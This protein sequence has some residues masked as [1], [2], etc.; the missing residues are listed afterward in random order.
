MGARN[1]RRTH[2]G[3]P[4]ALRADIGSIAI[5]VVVIALAT[6]GGSGKAPESDAAPPPPGRF[7]HGAAGTARN[8][9]GGEIAP[10]PTM[11]SWPGTGPGANGGAFAFIGAHYG[12]RWGIPARPNNS[13]GVGYCVME[14]VAGERTV[15]L[16]PD[17][18]AWDRG[19]M[20]RAAAVM[21]SFGGDRVVPYTIDAAG[22]YDVAS[23]EW[24]HPR[25]L[26]GGE[27]T[28]RRHVAVNF[29][30]KMFVED[31]SP[32]GV[33]A[34]RKLARDTAVVAGAGSDFVAL[35]NGYEVA[36]HL[37]DVAD[38]HHAVGGITLQ[39][40]WETPDGAAPT[41]P[42]IHPLRVRVTDSTGKPVAFVP[43]LQL[44]ATGIGDARSSGASAAVAMSNKSADDRARWHAAAAT[45]WP[46]LTMSRRLGDDR[47]F[48]LG[49]NPRSADVTGSDGVARFDVTIDGPSWELAFHA[50]AP[51][52]DVE[53]YAGSGVQGQITWAGQP[54]SASSH[55]RMEMPGRIAVRKVLDAADIQGDRDMSGFVFDVLST[56]GDGAVVASASTGTEGVTPPIELPV[57]EYRV[58]ET[59]RPAWAAGLGDGGPVTIAVDPAP[60]ADAHPVEVVYV[61]A[62]PS[63]SITTHASDAADGDK[64]LSPAPADDPRPFV[65]DSVTYTGLVPGTRYIARGE[66]V[67]DDCDGWCTA[68]VATGETD[69]VAAAADG[70]VDVTFELSA[71]STPRGGG[72]GVVL[73]DLLV[74]ASGRVVAEHRDPD[75][76]A[77]TVYFPHLASRLQRDDGGPPPASWDE[78]RVDVGDAI[79]DVVDHTGL[80]PGLPHRIEMTLHERGDDGTCTP[81]GL[82]TT[83]DLTPATPTGRIEVRGLALPAPGVYVAFQ[84]LHLVD[85]VTGATRLVAAHADCGDDA[86][87]LWAPLP[88]PPSTVPEVPAATTTSSPPSTAAP[89]VSTTTTTA[90]AAT[91]SAAPSTT[92]PSVNTIART[93]NDGSWSLAG[94]GLALIMLGVGALLMARCRPERPQPRR[95]S[96]QPQ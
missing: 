52:A 4:R 27:Y 33:V 3:N 86:Q 6:I 34:G 58:V 83:L 35:R 76:P 36:R 14:D 88:E 59:G 2:G 81:I 18:P 11:A 20:A 90:P 12:S 26:G 71:D 63:A 82:A 16:Q 61:N 62:V 37:A 24:H 28:R 47:R 55:E 51:T 8:G 94:G 92:S 15:T 91:T 70:V 72:R 44:S 41:T 84:H 73:Q 40:T 95:G 38:L 67:V 29:A 69:F 87:A 75:D 64:Y 78:R 50:Q 79:V 31:V 65:V 85:E 17:P 60:S 21:A 80:R 74:A 22:P 13:T 89:A 19:E 57:G 96:L 54:Q 7:D 45:G 23:G 10:S 66:L 25:L 56:A 48:A 32:S 77:Q 68:P 1:C 49:A 42:G 30:V 5:A 43:V 53:L 39:T 46:T 93:G 9:V